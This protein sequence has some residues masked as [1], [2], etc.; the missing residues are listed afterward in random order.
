ML[1]LLLFSQQLL[2]VLP[3]AHELSPALLSAVLVPSLLLLLLLQLQQ[4][5]CLCLAPKHL[6]LGRLEPVLRPSRD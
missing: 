4:R 6:R 3:P 2:L 5:S 1:P